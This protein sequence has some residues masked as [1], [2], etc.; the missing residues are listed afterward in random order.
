VTS[1]E[2][3]EFLI[4]KWNNASGWITPQVAGWTFADQHEHDN[5]FD[6]HAEESAEEL[7]K[8]KKSKIIRSRTTLKIKEPSC[9]VNEPINFLNSPLVVLNGIS[10]PIM[11]RKRRIQ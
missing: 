6:K 5:D 11:L 3:R 8:N 9:E 4:K 7:V 2:Y 10:S 1:N